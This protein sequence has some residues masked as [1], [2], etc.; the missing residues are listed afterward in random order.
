VGDLQLINRDTKA[1]NR[2]RAG[3]IG[4][5]NPV[6]TASL[7][8]VLL[9]RD[10]GRCMAKCP[11]LDLVTE[12]D[13][14]EQALQAMVELIQEYAQDFKAGEETYLKSPNRAHHKPYVDRVAACRDEWEVLEL[15]GIRH[16]H[17]HV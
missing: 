10:D 6:T 5:P 11:E 15:I 2:D 13:T 8:T 14:K 16:G 17:L 12:M 4:W 1:M 9:V 3:V 7:L